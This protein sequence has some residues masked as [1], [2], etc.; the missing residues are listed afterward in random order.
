MEKYPALLLNHNL[1]QKRAELGMDKAHYA[2]RRFKSRNNDKEDILRE[3]KDVDVMFNG[4]FAHKLK[5]NLKTKR[6]QVTIWNTF[7]S[8]DEKVLIDT[9]SAMSITFIN[10]VFASYIQ[11]VE[12][13]SSIE[14]DH[15]ILNR[16]VSIPEPNRKVHLVSS[17]VDT[18]S[19]TGE[20][21]S[22]SITNSF[23]RNLY[24]NDIRAKFVHIISSEAESVQLTNIISQ[25]IVINPDELLS[26]GP[27]RFSFESRIRKAI[28]Y[29]SPIKYS[30]KRKRRDHAKGLE[31]GIEKSL[32]TLR[33]LKE[34]TYYRHNSVALSK[35]EYITKSLVSRYSISS[36]LLWPVGFF[37]KPTRIVYTS[38]LVSAIYGV[39]YFV[40]DI[41]NGIHPSGPI[42][43][44]YHSC[45]FF[46]SAFPDS[47]NGPITLLQFSERIL[48]MLLV[49]SFTVSLVRKYLK[50]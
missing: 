21:E 25:D 27:E 31:I 23:V 40:M 14:F 45:K 41:L 36:Y 33:T 42:D 15:C 5:D 12:V 18:L 28:R 50:G 37:L 34:S 13:P 6:D 32:E 17:A 7:F 16:N 11:F 48:G 9:R 24:L 38:I 2:S 29:K 4:L 35:L 49:Y 8:A 20:F 44:A 22:V 30:F 10:C 3:Y 43:Y 26:T 47:F 19:L 1:K 39:I 46:F